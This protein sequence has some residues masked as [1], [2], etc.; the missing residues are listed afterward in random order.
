MGINATFQA[1]TQLTG[2]GLSAGMVPILQ[3]TPQTAP[4]NTNAPPPTT[5]TTTNG[6]TQWVWPA[7]S[8]G[9]SFTRVH[10]MPPPGSS[11]SKTVKGVNT[12][13]GFPGWTTGS[14]VLPATP[15]GSAYVTATAGESVIAV[16]S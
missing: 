4:A 2:S 5:Y 12:D 14:I 11:L 16:F 8:L 10:L 7:A 9:Y 15:G 6:T 3:D 1:T 13:T